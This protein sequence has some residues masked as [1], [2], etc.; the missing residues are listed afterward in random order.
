MKMCYDTMT[1]YCNGKTTEEM[2]YCQ[3][4]IGLIDSE[5]GIIGVFCYQ[6]KCRM[7]RA[8]NIRTFLLDFK[9]LENNWIPTQFKVMY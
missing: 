3:Y 7:F 2:N 6:M 1:Q 9:E 8:W 5:G 4:S